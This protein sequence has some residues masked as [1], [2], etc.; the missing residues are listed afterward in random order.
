MEGEE[1]G[2]HS[3]PPL[4]LF[5]RYESRSRQNTTPL[6]EFCAF[7]SRTGVPESLGSEGVAVSV[8]ESQQTGIQSYLHC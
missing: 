8:I 1:G 7:E 6:L 5:L 4:I 3:F 2:N